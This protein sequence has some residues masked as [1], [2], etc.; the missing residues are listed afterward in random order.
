[1]AV[2]T[3]TELIRLVYVSVA[4]ENLD[5]DDLD[6]IAE[7][8]RIKNERA[9]LTGFLIHQ[10]GRFHGVLEGP[11]RALFARMEVIMRDPRHHKLVV[12]R[13][14]GIAARRFKNWSVGFLPASSELATD[15]AAA[16]F[17]RGLTSRI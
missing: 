9:G 11:Q 7:V 4:A 13:E 6:A 3:I 8:S 17:L 1:M 14:D 16:Q 12:V 15:D 10:G 2:S 5:D